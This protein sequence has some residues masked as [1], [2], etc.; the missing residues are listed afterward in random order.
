[1]CGR[2]SQYGGFSEIK[3]RFGLVSGVSAPNVPSCYNAAPRQ[4]LLVVRQDVGRRIAEPMR[5]GLIPA[6]AKDPKLGDRA[7]N[8]RDVGE[9]G[10]SLEIRPMFREGWRAGRR[11]LIPLN[12]F[13]EW[14][15]LDTVKQPYA[16]G[17]SDGALMGV[18]GLWEAWRDGTTGTTVR[19]FTIIT[20]TANELLAPIHD[21][22]PVVIDPAEYQAWLEGEPEAARALLRPYPAERMRLWPVT[23]RI[24]RVGAIDGPECVKA[25]RG[26]GGAKVKTTDDHPSDEGNHPGVPPFV[27]PTGS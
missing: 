5:W 25:I 7:I 1:M 4:N 8:A 9:D 2:A 18:A 14:R 10:R 22:M 12:S 19:S 15:K 17:L 24:N 26:V 21:R 16:I 3:L 6:W 27:T 20:T 11:C 13:F 23:P